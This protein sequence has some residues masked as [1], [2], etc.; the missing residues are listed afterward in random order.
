M[1]SQNCNVHT[2]DPLSK[3]MYLFSQKEDPQY[4]PGKVVLELGCGSN[5]LVMFSALRNAR[6]VV[7][8]D[9]SP[10]AL[11]GMGANIALNAR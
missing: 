1:E 3:I 2:F 6:R 11:Q 10:A 5:P 8:T 7:S 4:P 9:G